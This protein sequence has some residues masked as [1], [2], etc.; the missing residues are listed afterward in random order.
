MDWWDSRFACV[1]NLNLFGRPWSG[2]PLLQWTSLFRREQSG[3]VSRGSGTRKS[4]AVHGQ[5][6]AAPLILPAGDHSEHVSCRVHR[7]RRLL[8]RSN[9]PRLSQRHKIPLSARF[10]W[11][12]WSSLSLPLKSNDLLR[13]ILE[14]A[15][16][17]P[18]REQRHPPGFYFTLLCKPKQVVIWPKPTEALWMVE[19]TSWA[20]LC[21]QLNH[22]HTLPR[23][24]HNHKRLS[25]PRK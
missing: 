23:L 8:K 7:V 24:D 10:S 12:S 4:T 22:K 20:K 9:Y 19:M 2:W 13:P 6:C 5:A 3:N 18:S 16:P 21:T 15:T 17:A 11:Q 25:A 14:E 1:G